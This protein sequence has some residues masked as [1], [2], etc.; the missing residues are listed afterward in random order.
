M[1]ARIG[2][3]ATDVLAD[4]RPASERA[5][6]EGS[7]GRDQ[8]DETAR[9]VPLGNARLSRNDLQAS[10]LAEGDALPDTALAA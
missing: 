2:D 10:A 8:G 6:E 4:V 5:R 9:G 1:G 7:P 3:G